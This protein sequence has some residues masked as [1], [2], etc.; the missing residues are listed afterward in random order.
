MT[1]IDEAV[2]DA[3]LLQEA[4]TKLAEKR[5]VNALSPRIKRL[6]EARLLN[7]EEIDF[8]DLLSDLEGVADDDAA[9]EEELETG[10][11]VMTAVAPDEDDLVSMEMPA[12]DASPAPESTAAPGVDYVSVHADGDVNIELEIENE[13]DEEPV[14]TGGAVIEAKANIRRLR[15]VSKT[16]ARRA[17][18]AKNLTE[19]KKIHTNT[20]KLKESVLNYADEP[21]F[22]GD[23]AINT[24]LQEAFT[25]LA[26]TQKEMEKVMRRYRRM[27]EGRRAEGMR[28]YEG[29][30]E[31]MAYEGDMEEMA[32][33]GD[34]EELDELDAVFEL[35]P[36]DDEEAEMLANLD[37]ADL[38]ITVDI[39]EE[40]E[41]GEEGEDFDDFEIEDE[42][43]GDEADESG[44]EE[45]G[46]DDEIVEID[47]SVLRRAL[48]EMRRNRRARRLSET[49]AEEADQF[50]G[51]E[52]AGDVI[53]IDE[54][55]LVNVLADE[56][57]RVSS[58]GTAAPAVVEGRRRRSR[59][60]TESR[61]NGTA[62][63]LAEAANE[64]RKLKQQLQEMNLFSAKLLY[65]NKIFNGRNVTAKQRR[66][67]V[68]A[69]DNAKTLREA[70]L[71]YRSLLQS[72]DKGSNKRLSE[73]RV[74]VLGSS[75]KSVPS[76]QP[77]SNG[78]EV[79][80]WA[81]LAGIKED[82]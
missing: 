50:G 31:E 9:D 65:V 16:L 5:L 4:A 27:T 3:A 76:A 24:A 66:A 53:E 41:E 6:V 30:M 43:E 75:S 64:N 26:S 73:S 15:L 35:T 49:A 23:A 10:S 29:D 81:T 14:L 46:D 57:G 2:R 19:A 47:E 54:E 48:I 63:R 72:I 18:S 51:G 69:M 42:A 37:L 8:E 38:D 17:R 62:R 82:K 25:T 22:T 52:S 79:D 60:V 78:A 20:V 80:R 71:L 34:M 7:E 36:E 32:Y 33:E 70:K 28:A 21:L 67:I 1:I 77:A 68:E 13:D 44:D 74:R 12:F 55:T 45:A 40:G 59:R 56:L 61:S 58:V 11:E 39:E